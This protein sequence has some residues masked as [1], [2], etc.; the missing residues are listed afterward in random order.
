MKPLVEWVQRF[1]IVP[2]EP[3]EQQGGQPGVRRAQVAEIV[4]GYRDA[5]SDIPGDILAD[6]V[7]AT[8]DRHAYRNLPTPGDIRA[9]AEAEMRERSDRLRRLR[10]A[11]MRADMDAKARAAEPSDAPRERTPAELAAAA[12]AKEAALQALSEGPV[13]AMPA[14][15]DDLRQVRDDSTAAARRRVAEGLA[16]FRKIE[17]PNTPWSAMQQPP[18]ASHAR[19][20]EG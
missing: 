4:R 1:G 10:T 5:L 13:K 14:E 11:K 8:V 18:A 7:K 9:R 6:A 20:M 2:L 16:G 17:R 19:R 15:R 12:A 3:T